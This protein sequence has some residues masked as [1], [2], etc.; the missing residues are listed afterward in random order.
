MRDVCGYS[1]H[2][3]LPEVR[4]VQYGEHL[5]AAVDGER[6]CVGMVLCTDA[7]AT[8]SCGEGGAAYAPT[9]TRRT[10][11]SVLASERFA[12]FLENN[13]L[14]SAMHMRRAW[15]HPTFVGFTTKHKPRIID[16]IVVKRRFRSS[17]LGVYTT[18]PPIKS[19]HRPV[20]SDISVK[21]ATPKSSDS[22]K[23]DYTMLK[24][25]DVKKNVIDIVNKAN[26]Y[27]EFCSGVGQW[28]KRLPKQEKFNLQPLWELVVGE[29]EPTKEAYN[30]AAKR[31]VATITKC[32]E[33]NITTS[34]RTA[35]QAIK[36]LRPTSSLLPALPKD[37]YYEHF[38]ADCLKF[39]PDGDAAPGEVTPVL[40]PLEGW[41]VDPPSADEI[42]AAAQ[43][44]KA[45]KAVGPDGVPNA[46]LKIPELADKLAEFFETAYRGSPPEQWLVSEAVPLYKK[47]PR[48]MLSNYRRITLSS[49]AAKLYNA[50]LLSRLRRMLD[51]KLRFNQNGFRVNRGTTQHILALRR[52]VELTRQQ[53]DGKLCALFVD[54]SSAFDSVYWHKLEE[55]L[56]AYNVPQQL[57]TAILSL[58]ENARITVRT[59]DGQTT[60]IP[61][62]AGVLQGDTLAPYLFV[63]VV[64]HMLRNVTVGVE[65]VVVGGANGVRITDLDFADDLCFLTRDPA[66]AQALID[67]LVVEAAK[68][69]LVVN[70]KPGKTE[71]MCWGM[72]DLELKH[73]DVVVSRVED[74]KYLGSMVAS[75]EEDFNRRRQQ[76]WGA[77]QG[78][79]AIWKSDLKLDEKVRIFRTVVLSIF[80][81]ASE[82]W[83]V[84][85][86][87]LVK[88]KGAYTNMVR[89]VRGVRVHSEETR[90][91]NAEL[92]EG[93]PSVEA[94]LLSR[95]L[96][97]AGHCWR[98]DQPVKHL[99]FEPCR[100]KKKRG[101]GILTYPKVLEKDTGLGQD[102]LQDLMEDR[103]AW[104]AFVKQ[105]VGEV[106]QVVVSKPRTTTRDT[107]GRKMLQ[108]EIAASTL[109]MRKKNA[110]K[111]VDELVCGTCLQKGCTEHCQDC[112]SH[113]DPVDATCPGSV[114]QAAEVA[115]CGGCP[116]R[117]E[118]TTPMG[119]RPLHLSGSPW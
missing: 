22:A 50:T 14:L 86:A 103:A 112:A 92:M 5:Q 106:S 3:E 73:G 61:L 82:T 15:L 18:A 21:Y 30:R 76:A 48:S 35:W 32:F 90:V 33:D 10:P 28:V 109:L 102:E 9:L 8:L 58:Y 17:V 98:S 1:P 56:A 54:F 12:S 91:S 2:S 46:V 37:D 72:D 85:E 20:I 108:G 119:H 38:K 99:L 83:T 6:G 23:R 79:D 69:G 96:R 70:F 87:L 63:L 19:D 116:H 94:L 111:K 29:G 64:D 52:L 26:D 95:R 89:Y 100:G 81:Y 62:H 4:H 105:K 7:N 59:P 39:K 51:D 67:K 97:F 115:P 41:N 65:G 110:R 42:R 43:R 68:Y 45:S 77:V 55:V 118:V 78:L 34:S 113:H 40:E 31:Q 75:C 74:Y 27:G 104:D 80:L 117:C 114:L 25:P 13:S 36:S 16:H 88:I 101:R 60:P 47:G 84:G 53:T 57:I 49:C 11:K 24:D 93:F 44:L 66:E 71:Y 107:R